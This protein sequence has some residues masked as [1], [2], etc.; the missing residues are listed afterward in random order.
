MGMGI[1][2]YDPRFDVGGIYSLEQRLKWVNKHP[3]GTEEEAKQNFKWVRDNCISVVK[4]N[5]KF[6]TSW[7][8]FGDGF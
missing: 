6:K 7:L 2:D 1:M 4:S 5:T 8:Y 3:V